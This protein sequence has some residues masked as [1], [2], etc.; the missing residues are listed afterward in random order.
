M[1]ATPVLGHEIVNNTHPDHLFQQYL[2]L[3]VQLMLHDPLHLPL[4]VQTLSQRVQAAAYYL[5]A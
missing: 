4:L 2:F 1:H 3:P 5:I